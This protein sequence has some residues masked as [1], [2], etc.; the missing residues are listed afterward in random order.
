MALRSVLVQ[1]VLYVPQYIP[2]FRATLLLHRGSMGLAPETTPGYP[3]MPGVFSS[4]RRPTPSPLNPHLW[5][6][7]LRRHPDRLF[8]EYVIQGLK[9]GIRIG[10]DGM[11]LPLAKWSLTTCRLRSPWVASWAS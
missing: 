8:V 9:Q 4:H 10:F 1:H 6:V 7:A 2:S 5:E 3:A 11:A